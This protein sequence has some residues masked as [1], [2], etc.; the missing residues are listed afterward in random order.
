MKTDESRTRLERTLV[1]REKDPGPEARRLSR[2]VQVLELI[3]TPEA[4]ALLKTWAEADG[5]PGADGARAAIGRLE[6]RP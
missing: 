6:K 4:K 3:A 5:S 2:A 1:A